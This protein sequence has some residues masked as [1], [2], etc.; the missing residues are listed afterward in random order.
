MWSLYCCNYIWVAKIVQGRFNG[1]IPTR[2][3]LIQYMI[4][5]CVEMMSSCSLKLL[6]IPK[7]TLQLS[8]TLHLGELFQLL[9][10]NINLKPKAVQDHR[11]RHSNLGK[12]LGQRKWSQPCIFHMLDNSCLHHSQCFPLLEK[13]LS[14]KFD[15][16]DNFINS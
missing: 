8:T 7:W 13:I 3:Q 2:F 9:N 12:H 10:F 11:W 15:L 6:T 5:T 14:C 16:N 4:F 1:K